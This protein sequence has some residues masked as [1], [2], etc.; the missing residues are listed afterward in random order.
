[1][2][3]C[4][5]MQFRDQLEIRMDGWNDTT[6]NFGINFEVIGKY[7]FQMLHLDQVDHLFYY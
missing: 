1:M 5:F 2:N 7:Q 3:L 4:G 6:E